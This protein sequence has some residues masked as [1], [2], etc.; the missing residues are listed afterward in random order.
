MT[1]SLFGLG[2]A[3]TTEMAAQTTPGLAL[4]GEGGPSRPRTSFADSLKV[5]PSQ[6]P[7]PRGGDG[8]GKTEQEMGASS[9]PSGK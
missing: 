4:R 6:T 1:Q 7:P 5:L 3:P 2:A 9:D 8:D